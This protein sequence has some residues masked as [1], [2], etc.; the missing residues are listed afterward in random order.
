RARDRHHAYR[1]MDIGVKVINRET[2]L[3]SLDLAEQVLQG[4]GLSAEAARAGA[5][6]FREYDEALMVRQQA[7]YQD[8]ARLTET[9][10][11]AMEEL[12]NL[13]ESDSRAARDTAATPTSADAT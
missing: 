13:F 9:T 3:S 5:R 6:R 8:E 10:R 12:E 7:V 2:Y 1:L 11:Q 4:L